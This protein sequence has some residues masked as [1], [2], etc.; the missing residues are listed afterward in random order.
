[1]KKY[2]LKNHFNGIKKGTHFY[3]IAESEFIGIKEYV[4]RT[5]DLSVRISINESE[6]NKNFTLINSYFYKEE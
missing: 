4:L 1:M 3:L 6:L 5:I 2:K